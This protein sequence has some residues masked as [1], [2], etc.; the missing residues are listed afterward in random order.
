MAINSIN[1]TYIGH[2]RTRV[3]SGGRTF[4]V[5]QR[6]KTDQP[7]SEFCPLELVATSLGA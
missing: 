1:V 7:D 4:I 2:E 5:D 6:T 3:E